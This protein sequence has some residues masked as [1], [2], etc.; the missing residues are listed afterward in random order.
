MVGWVVFG[1]VLCLLGLGVGL[2]V[3]LILFCGIDLCFVIMVIV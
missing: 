3:L 1:F 2:F